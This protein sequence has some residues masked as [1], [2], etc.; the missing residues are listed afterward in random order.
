MQPTTA[1]SIISDAAS[2]FTDVTSVGGQVFTVITEAGR[3]AFT[4]ATGRRWWSSHECRGICFHGGDSG[5]RIYRRKVF[6]DI[7]RLGGH[8][9]TVVSDQAGHLATL[10][11]S[12]ARVVTSVEAS[13]YTAATSLPTN[14]VGSNSAARFGTSAPWLPAPITIALGSVAAADAEIAAISQS[15]ARI[16]AGIRSYGSYVVKAA[17]SEHIFRPP[18]SYAWRLPYLSRRLRPGV[19]SSVTVVNSNEA[20]IAEWDS[21]TVYSFISSFATPS[22]A[23]ICLHATHIYTTLS[24]QFV[25]LIDYRDTSGTITIANL[26]RCLSFAT[27]LNRKARGIAENIP[28][29]L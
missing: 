29:I 15:T 10:A 13:V 18:T 6:T 12:G 11:V 20:H 4:L 28:A 8:E 9:F 23:A 21:S 22:T 27:K 17:P 16:K 14:T 19:E 2:I 26:I 5:R 3:D 1:G 25:N 7:T 24:M